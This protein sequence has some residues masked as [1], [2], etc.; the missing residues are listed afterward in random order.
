MVKR[1][2]ARERESGQGTGDRR[3]LVRVPLPKL[4]FK[5][6]VCGG[7]EMKGV[8]RVP[9]VLP[10]SLTFAL[11]RLLSLNRPPK[12]ANLSQQKMC[13]VDTSLRL[14][15]ATLGRA[16]SIAH[17]LSCSTHIRVGGPVSAAA[18][19]IT[20]KKSGSQAAQ[21]KIMMPGK[22]LADITPPTHKE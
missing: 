11:A 10:N 3:F 1:G 7:G 4:V 20:T 5:L 18:K 2:Q 16:A 6:V 9:A 19:C 15:P 8:M 22:H 13:T 12:I 17:F 14:P 21:I